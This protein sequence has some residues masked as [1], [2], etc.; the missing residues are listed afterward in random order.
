[1]GLFSRN[2][3]TSCASSS[4]ARAPVA[5]STSAPARK[6]RGAVNGTSVSPRDGNAIVFEEETL[7]LSLSRKRRVVSLN[8]VAS[9]TRKGLCVRA[10]RRVAL[11]GLEDRLSMVPVIAA[12]LERAC[13]DGEGFCFVSRG[14]RVFVTR[15]FPVRFGLRTVPTTREWLSRTLFRSSS[16]DAFSTHSR[17]P[18]DAWRAAGGGGA[19][20]VRAPPRDAS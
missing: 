3:A 18:T 1:M 15:S 2:S 10:R 4:P 17:T 19:R 14:L 7:S 16:L 11:S 9:R 8:C 12:V 20:D 5:S 6:S 13:L